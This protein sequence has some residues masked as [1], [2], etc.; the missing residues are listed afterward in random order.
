MV[1]IRPYD[2]E[3]PLG[4]LSDRQL[5]Q[6]IQSANKALKKATAAA[7]ALDSRDVVQGKGNEALARMDAGT[8]VL[9]EAVGERRRRQAETPRSSWVG[10]GLA[11]F[12]EAAQR[13]QEREPSDAERGIAYLVEHVRWLDLEGVR[14]RPDLLS[15]EQ[16]SELRRLSREV[17]AY[18]W[19]ERG[20][21]TDEEKACIEEL[22]GV[23]AGARDF[24]K[25]QRERRELEAELANRREDRR[26]MTL[27][28]RLAYAKPGSVELPSY[29]FA[30]LRDLDRRQVG[31]FT[32]GDLGMLSALLFMF[33]NRQSLFPS[34]EF[35]EEADGEPVLVVATG[36]RQGFRLA[37]QI[38]PDRE[39]M[40]IGVGH[41]HELD[42]L[43]TLEKNGFFMTE[44]SRGELR[45]RLGEKGRELLREVERQ[46]VAT[47]A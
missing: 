10:Q 17:D 40:G 8:S 22:L 45:V 39:H 27:K 4:G 15:E 5:E 23:A 34:G 42:S 43:R 38:N 16:G 41:I 2:K 33:S 29:V 20:D 1:R 28:P 19:G 47:P 30:W 44:K 18:L 46:E 25:R 32:V 6:R 13:A 9:A 12:R 14:F 21:L 26:L 31:S 35:L 37:G 7:D 3:R 24:F 36:G 11:F